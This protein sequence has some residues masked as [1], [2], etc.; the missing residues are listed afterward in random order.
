MDHFFDIL[1]E[2]FFQRSSGR[3]V[4][5][6]VKKSVFEREQFCLCGTA[7]LIRCIRMIEYLLIEG[8]QL[9]IRSNNQVLRFKEQMH[10]LHHLRGWP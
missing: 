9:E 10:A 6:G 3:I 2:R 8:W 4:G 1:E 5:Q 7:E